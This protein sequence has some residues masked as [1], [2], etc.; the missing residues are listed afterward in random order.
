MNSPTFSSSQAEEFGPLF[1]GNGKFLK[2]QK[3]ENESIRFD[4]HGS[5]CQ[6]QKMDR[7][8]EGAESKEASE[9]AVIIIQGKMKEL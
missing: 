7:A 8:W 2:D 5:A 6:H 3:Q 9:Q 4:L 1:S